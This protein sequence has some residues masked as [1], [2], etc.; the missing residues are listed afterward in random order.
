MADVVPLPE[1]TAAWCRNRALRHYAHGEL[2]NAVVA[3]SAGLRECEGEGLP[4]DRMLGGLLPAAEGDRASVRQW[5][6]EAT[7]AQRMPGEPRAEAPAPK[8]LQ[9][10]RPLPRMAARENAP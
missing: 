7:G 5:I 8:C 4:L 9:C 2:T 10:G 3:V 6:D 1:R